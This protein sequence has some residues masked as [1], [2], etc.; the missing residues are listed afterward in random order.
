MRIVVNDIAASKTGALSVLKDFYNFIKRDE[1]RYTVSDEKKEALEWIFLLSDCYLEETENIQ[2]RVLPEIKKSRKNRLLFD[3]YDGGGYIMSLK[4]DVYFSLQNTLAGKVR[5]RTVLYVH[6][7]LCFQNV[8]N[9]SFFKAEER[10]YAVYQHIIGKLIYSSIKR[11]DKTIV[12]TEWMKKEII[13]R[14]GISS[15]RICKITPDIIIP[16]TLSPSGYKIPEITEFFYPSGVMLYKNHAC[17]IRA[18]DLLISEGI[19][20]FRIIFTVTEDEL[21]QLYRGDINDNII[22]A[23]SLPREK[24]LESYREKTLIFPSY[25]ESFGYPPAE[26]RSL[27]GLVFASDTPACREVLSGYSRAFFFDPFNPEELKE[28]MKRKILGELN[29]PLSPSPESHWY[30]NG[31]FKKPESWQL[32]LNELVRST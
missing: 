32:V 10:E 13:R 28:L 29:E 18:S 4:P 15:D 25:I 31:D 20:N 7:P 16:D 14:T 9:F 17:V 6:Q 30:P 22:C 26:A 8:K 5:C 12:Q 2:V 1:N 27:G 11:A 19:R 24:V 3:L 21:R 23:G